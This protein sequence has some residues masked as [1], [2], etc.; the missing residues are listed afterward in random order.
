LNRV[1]GTEGISQGGAIFAGYQSY[2]DVNDCILWENTAG[3]GEQI[4]I[5][6]GFEFDPVPSTV[7]ISYSDIRYYETDKERAISVDEGSTLNDDTATLFSDDPEFEPLPEALGNLAQAYYLDQNLSP[8]IDAGSRLAFDAGLSNYT[9]SIFNTPDRDDVDLGYHYR[10]ITR[11]ICSSTDLIP[12]GDIDLR[13][14]AVFASEWLTLDVCGDDNDWCNGTDFNFDKKVDFDDLLVFVPCWLRYDS[15]PPYPSPSEWANVPTAVAGT[16]DTIEMSA[17]EHHDDWWPDANIEYFFDCVQPFDG[18]DSGW[19]SER[20]WTV[21]GLAPEFHRY[22]VFARDGSG[23]ETLPSTEQGVLPGA[24]TDIPQ[25][26]FS[27]VPEQVAGALS[28]EMTA[29]DYTSLGL[30][31][32]PGGLYE[33]RYEFAEVSGSAGGN[34]RGYS[35]SRTYTDGGLTGGG[36][37]SYQVRMGLFYN[38]PIEGWIF[39]EE[40]EW[41]DIASVVIEDVPPV[42]TDPPNDPGLDLENPLYYTAKHASGSPAN[43]APIAGRTWHVVTSIVMVDDSDVEY[44]FVNTDSSRYNSGNDGDPDGIEWR[45]ADNVAGLFYPNGEPQVP[46]LY[47]ADRGI[48]TAVFEGWQIFVRDRSDNQNQSV[49]SEIRS[50]NTSAP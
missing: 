40:G 45:N 49:P 5:S 39:A 50:I 43:S 11:D 36:T 30:E 32:L 28:A 3:K 21:S 47:W 31:P 15:E 19:I 26:Q 18:P 44:K 12:T 38:D 4:A 8:C 1:E 37:Y 20:E 48:S 9:T 22:V 17:V 7:T 23:I 27:Q 6:T 34:G 29:A 14:W 13:D 41:S 10:L 42:D 46:W 24:N 2:V 33:M 16:F 35:T 25:G